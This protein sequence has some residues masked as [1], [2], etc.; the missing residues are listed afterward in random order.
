[1]RRL[2]V[3][4]L[5]L[6]LGLAAIT[7]VLTVYVPQAIAETRR[8]PSEY[9]T[10][11]SA[12]NAASDGDTIIVDQGIYYENIH[13][14]YPSKAITVKSTNP[15]A[16]SVVEN[17]IID[18][19]AAS[20][21]VTFHG[22]GTGPALE[23]LT[24]RNGKNS[25]GNG[26]GGIACL[27][28]NT[29]PLATKYAS[30][31]ITSCIIT[32]NHV[33]GIGITGFG[34]GIFC[35]NNCSPTINKCII[36]SNTAN[37]G[38]GI[39]AQSNGTPI[40]SQCAIINNIASDCGGG[41]YWKSLNK[42]TINNCTLI[43]N[44]A[45]KGGGIYLTNCSLDVLITNCTFTLNSAAERGN[46]GG[47][48]FVS[49]RV[50]VSNCILYGDINGEIKWLTAISYIVTYSDVQGGFF[51]SFDDHNIDENPLFVD[52]GPGTGK[53]YH[54]KSD[55]PCIDKGTDV[56]APDKD[57][58]DIIR[59]KDGDG[60]GTVVSDIGAYEYISSNLVSLA[61][62]S[63]EAN[64]NHIVITWNTL[65]EDDTAGFNLWRAQAEGG[66]YVKINPDIIPSIGG[67]SSEAEYIYD[68]M[69]STVGA[70]YY[71]LEEIDDKG[72]STFYGPVSQAIR[73]N[74]NRPV[75]NHPFGYEQL[76]S[77]QSMLWLYITQHPYD[78]LN[79]YSQQWWYLLK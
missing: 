43:E 60:N 50:N 66:E 73:S 21:V 23:G 42:P 19:G 77:L 1:M 30:P 29:A 7:V 31:Q 9:S 3:L 71:Q 44:K 55:S 64:G 16:Q 20:P 61:Y 2:S 78:Y 59:P 57:K 79:F 14:G 74:S 15:N 32:D 17:T 8:V 12:I 72:L 38:G 75:E 22:G 41:V 10:I 24:L 27:A 76:E 65:S 47:I 25:Y 45:F 36:S 68:D 70:Y 18:G 56:G 28:E 69:P 49:S 54:L 53:D 11:Q 62:F 51:Y 58:D 33:A 4:A 5:N 48:Y 40:I 67:A 35:Y 39:Y 34:G 46:G 6:V 37:E 13:F 52:P 63:A 26:G